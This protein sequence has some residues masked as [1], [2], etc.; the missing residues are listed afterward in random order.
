M[1]IRHSKA[2]KSSRFQGFFIPSCHTV[3]HNG[4]IFI[5]CREPSRLLGFFVFLRQN[6]FVYAQLTAQLNVF[7]PD[8]LVLLGLIPAVVKSFFQDGV[9]LFKL[10]HTVIGLLQFFDPRSQ[11]LILFTKRLVDFFCFCDRI[12]GLLLVDA[13][14]YKVPLQLSDLLHDLY[15]CLLFSRIVQ[16]RESIALRTDQFDCIIDLIQ[17]RFSF[18]RCIVAVC[19]IKQ[20]LNSSIIGCKVVLLA[21]LIDFADGLLMFSFANT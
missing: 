14:I 10:A 16:T 18:G 4:F 8:L 9:S 19:F 3:C 13:Q 20:I 12:S 11:P 21:V 15:F 6:L 17:E 7:R 1:R 2:L 5:F